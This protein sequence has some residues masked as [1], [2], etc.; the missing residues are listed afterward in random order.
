MIL[1]IRIHQREAVRCFLSV[2]K[3][4]FSTERKTKLYVEVLRSALRMTLPS[5]RL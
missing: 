3:W 4:K 1:A 5:M 2:T